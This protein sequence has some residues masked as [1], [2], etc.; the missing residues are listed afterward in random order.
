MDRV[1][2]VVPT[3]LK[4]GRTEREIGKDIA[5]A[6]IAEGHAMVDFVIV[7]SGPN[8]EIDGVFGSVRYSAP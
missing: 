6:I 4:P 7:A 8:G 2:Q 5:E 1:H 3:L